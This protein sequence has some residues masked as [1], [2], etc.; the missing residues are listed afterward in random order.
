MTLSLI[1]TLFTYLFSLIF[2]KSILDVYY[3]FDIV[4]ISKILA[5]AIVSWLPF[6][7]YYKLRARCFPEAHEKLEVVEESEN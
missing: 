5:L 2:L 1:G 7:L 6:F 3:I 4:T